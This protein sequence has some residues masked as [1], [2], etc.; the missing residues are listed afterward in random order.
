MSNMKERIKVVI[1]VGDGTSAEKIMYNGKATYSG[2][3]H[4]VWQNLKKS[5][6]NKYTFEEFYLSDFA[7]FNSVVDDVESGKYDLAIDSFYFTEGRAQKV[8]FSIPHSLDSIVVLQRE[9]K[10]S[11]LK[12]FIFILKNAWK[13]VLIL[14][15]LG[16]IFGIILFATD[17]KRLFNSSSYV[18]E[19]KHLFFNRTLLTGLSTMLGQTGLLS[20]SASLTLFSVLSVTII[21]F[22]AFILSNFIQAEIISLLLKKPKTSLTKKNVGSKRLMGI[23]GF[24][25]TTKLLKLNPNIDSKNYRGSIRDHVDEFK[26]NGDKYDGF[27][28]GYNIS[29]ET[30]KDDDEIIPVLGFGNELAGFVVSKTKEVFLKDLNNSILTLRGSSK[31]EKICNMYFGEMDRP[32]CSL[33]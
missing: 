33:T 27:V 3:G 23:N 21:M 32:V 5:L 18:Q 15:G 1:M 25:S 17:K 14:L 24:A 7:S 11:Y 30:I 19:N 6:Q 13:L 9:E 4:D 31:L 29:Y 26:R 12:N 28:L 22:I 16:F 10:K 20:E 8:N 2:F